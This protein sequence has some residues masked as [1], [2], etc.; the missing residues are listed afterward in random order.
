MQGEYFMTWTEKLWNGFRPKLWT[1]SSCQNGTE[2][3]S[4][5]LKMRKGTLSDLSERF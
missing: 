3:L 2:V 5:E 4:D 1:Q